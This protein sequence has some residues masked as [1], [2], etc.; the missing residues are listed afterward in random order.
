MLNCS[1]IYS[2]TNCCIDDNMPHTSSPSLW[3]FLPSLKASMP[4][5]FMAFSTVTTAYSIP[6]GQ[7]SLLAPSPACK[8]LK[9]NCPKLNWLPS[10]PTLHL[11]HSLSQGM[12]CHGCSCPTIFLLLS[13][14]C[15]SPSAVNS[16][17]SLKGCVS[18]LSIT[19]IKLPNFSTLS[20]FIWI[21]CH[22]LP[23]LSPST[24][25]YSLKNSQTQQSHYH[26]PK[27]NENVNPQKRLVEECYSTFLHQRQNLNNPNVH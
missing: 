16:T 7:L 4:T 21:V 9:L 11:L 8:Y 14:S 20:L 17:S 27:R 25:I 10:P 19:S 18:L 12:Y 2:E 3:V 26:V 22:G 13:P 1:L 5:A 6:A 15:P 24:P 23:A